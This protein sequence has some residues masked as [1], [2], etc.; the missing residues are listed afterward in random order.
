M[1]CYCCS[2]WAAVAD[3]LP[4][5]MSSTARHFPSHCKIQ[6]WK[7]LLQVRVDKVEGRDAYTLTVRFEEGGHALAHDAEVF[8]HW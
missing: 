7:C 2:C 3:A 1:R 6:I 4:K 5:A 8:L